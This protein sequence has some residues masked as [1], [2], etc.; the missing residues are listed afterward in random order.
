MLVAGLRTLARSAF[1]A[2]DRGFDA[3]F[4]PDW[5]PMYQLGALGWFFFWITIASGVYLFIFFDTGI[6]QAYESLEYLT[7]VQWYAGGVMRSFRCI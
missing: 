5:N 3:A 6:T 4:G 2:I 1:E 7:N